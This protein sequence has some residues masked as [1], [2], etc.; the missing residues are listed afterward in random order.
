MKIKQHLDDKY[1][2]KIE[3]V[4]FD[5]I[6][7]L[8]Q[9]RS[10]TSILYKMLSETGQFNILTA[11]HV[12]Y[13]DELL[14]I[15]ENNLDEKKKEELDKLFISKGIITR[16]TDNVKVN[17]DYAYEY[18]YIFLKNNYPF[19][20]TN[21]NKWLLDELCKKLKYI[22]KNKHP[23]LLKNPHDFTNFIYLKKI[24]PNAKFI[25]IHRHPVQI[26]NSTMRLWH[27]N[28]ENKNEYLAI[29]SKKYDQI[30][31][32]PL[33]LSAMRFYYTSNFPIGSLETIYRSTKA[34]KIYL[35][36]INQ[37]SNK[38]YISIK[39]EDLCKK[40]NK[41]ISEIMKLLHLEVNKDFSNQI[42]QRN[43]DLLHNVKFFKTFIN[44]KMKSYIEYF[45]YIV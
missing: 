30:F 5:P 42:R 6:F 20:V 26:I 41:T 38:D 32:N 28:L 21:K 34:T 43:L 10:G 44:K 23:I 35:K 19:W 12:Y 29:F 17:A 13:Y 18:M 9:H 25:F 22:S 37:L 31:K 11:Y 45:S 4:S 36:N 2:S 24:Y 40:P 8:G 27:T 15:H 16:K 14:H 1:L 33:Y 39:Y 3:N 7:I